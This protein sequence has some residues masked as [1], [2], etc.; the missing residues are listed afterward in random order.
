MFLVALVDFYH[1]MSFVGMPPFLIPNDSPN[2]ATTF[3]IIA[4]L[5][6]GLG[7]LATIILPSLLKIR[8]KKIFFLIL[9][10]LI[11]MV[12][13]I[14]ATYYPHLIP[15]MYIDGQGLTK[16]KIFL[17]IIVI[18]TYLIGIT[19]LLLKYKNRVNSL[20]IPLACALLAGIFSEL[21]FTLYKDVYGVYKHFYWAFSKIS[22]VLCYF[23]NHFHTEY[24]LPYRDLSCS[25]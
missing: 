16:I 14:I 8:F 19:F 15:P 1:V 5:I 6:G 7:L 21:S 18:I 3:W 4:R 11:S 23:Q 24:Q 25:C 9:P 20:L 12:I 10:T 17:E 2:R 22:N 13:L